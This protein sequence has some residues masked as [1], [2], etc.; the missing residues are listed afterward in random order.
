MSYCKI[1]EYSHCR[2]LCQTRWCFEDILN[3]G[4]C[5]RPGDVL[6]IFSMQDFVS[7]QMMFWGYS[8]CRI[9]CETRWCFEDIFTAEFCV[10]PGNVLRI[11]SMRDFVQ[12]QELF[13]CLSKI[14]RT[15]VSL[16]FKHMITRSSKGVWFSEEKI[17]VQFQWMGSNTKWWLN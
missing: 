4:F 13:C 1:G 12:D 6:R 3:A 17:L 15:C 8:H 7:D 2:I 16:V 5:V 10:R 9:L 11:F 14:A